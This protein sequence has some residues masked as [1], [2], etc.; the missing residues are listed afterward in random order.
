MPPTR[1]EQTGG[2][3]GRSCDAPEWH[4]AADQ[5]QDCYK[6][7]TPGGA[8]WEL[9]RSGDFGNSLGVRPQRRAHPNALNKCSL[10]PFEMRQRTRNG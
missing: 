5:G 9:L 1:A 3:P 2:L 8:R 7:V 4:G 6:G 10:S